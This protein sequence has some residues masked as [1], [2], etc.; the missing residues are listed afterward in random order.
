MSKFTTGFNALDI[1]NTIKNIKGDYDS[2]M[3]ALHHENEEKFVNK[4]AGVWATKRAIKFFKLYKDDIDSLTKRV[5]DLTDVAI[6]GINEDGKR[7]ASTTENDYTPVTYTLSP[8]KLNVSNIKDNIDGD[9][10]IYESEALSIVQNLTIVKEHVVLGL[11]NGIK[12]VNSS[13]FLGQGQSD[14]LI[15]A[16]TKLKDI[17]ERQFNEISEAATRIVKEEVKTYGDRGSKISF[18]I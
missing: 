15:A 1:M 13:G 6:K 18:E 14:E 17:V 2:I 9:A 3:Y 8:N 4:M 5:A 7:W 11:D 16:F 10:G 12:H